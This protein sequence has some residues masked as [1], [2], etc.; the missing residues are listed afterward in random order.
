MGRVCRSA[1]QGLAG[2]AVPMALLSEGMSAGEVGAVFAGVTLLGVVETFLVS[3]YS[4]RGR[5]RASFTL[6][7][8]VTAAST[9]P[10]LL[11][12][13][14]GWLSLA[15]IAGGFGGGSGATVAA[16][17]AYQ[18]SEYGWLGGNFP[19]EIRNRL[20]GS[21]SALSVFG[22][23]LGAVV[24]L[25][26]PEW[27][28]ATGFGGSEVDQ[29][30]FMMLV[31][32]LLALAAAC[33]G[34][35]FRD[36]PQRLP[37]IST[38]AVAGVRARLRALWPRQSRKELVQL[39][40]VNGVNGVA[41]GCYGP[42]V[43]VWLIAQFHA[44]AQLIGLMNLVGAVTAIAGDASCP[45]I[46][47]RFG[48]VRSII[49]TR[50]V[51]SL[52]IVPIAFAPTLAWAEVLVILRQLVQRL[53]M[54]LRESYAVA[55]AGAEERS[56]F[57]ALASL[58]AQGAQAASTDLSGRLIGAVGFQIPFVGAAG[59]QLGS[60]LL[61]LRYF[62][63]RPPPEEV[64]QRAVLVPAPARAES[65]GGGARAVEEPRPV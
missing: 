45:A 15:T 56:R 25:G 2:V 23:A 36:V 13:K 44:G 20:I 26:A 4:D 50:S 35:A 8:F 51:Q 32:G 54:P 62:T 28:Q 19:A 30:R 6:L 21:F 52:L 17:G 7:P 3:A 29:A 9:V 34:M 46:A 41:V 40:I 58:T 10:F 16:V 11:G 12:G 39:S 53:N 22:V 27:A 33:L 59:L 47:R 43:T 61:F 24:T 38:P 63:R 37:A 65:E 42:F 1:W 60:A 48:M 64:R 14:L 5:L 18:P 55:S 31:V 49:V 57:T